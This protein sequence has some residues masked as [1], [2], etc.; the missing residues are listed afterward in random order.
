MLQVVLKPCI[1]QLNDKRN[2]NLKDWERI[3]QGLYNRIPS[4]LAKMRESLE[5]IDTDPIHDDIETAK[6]LLTEIQEK[7]CEN[8]FD[9]KNFLK[10]SSTASMTVSLVPCGDWGVGQGRNDVFL[11]TF[12]EKQI[13]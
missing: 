5:N 8:F 4:N 10:I 13:G 11:L 9:L 12:P 2:T 7:V 1:Y 6:K 3:L